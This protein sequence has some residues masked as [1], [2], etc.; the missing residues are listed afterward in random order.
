MQADECTIIDKAVNH[1][2]KLKNTFEKLK[3]ENLEGFQEHNI[4]LIS[5]QKFPDV[6]N[7]WEK[8]FG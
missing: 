7:S 5:S 8:L 6:G 2:L 4:R 3:R 1:I